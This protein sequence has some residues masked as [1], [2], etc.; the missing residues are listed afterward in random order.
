VQKTL[1][2][3]KF[4]YNRLHVIG[5][6]LVAAR[7][8]HLH[9][10]NLTDGSHVSAWKHP[11]V[12]SVS[13]DLN[14]TA[15]AEVKGNE[16]SIEAISAEQ[17]LSSDPAEPPA[18]RQKTANTP[19][20]DEEPPNGA[21]GGTRKKEKRGRGTVK[22]ENA[23]SRQTFMERPLVTLLASSADGTYLIAVS[24]H[25]KTVWVFQHDGQGNLKQISRRYV[26]GDFCRALCSRRFCF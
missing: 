19:G 15:E 14:M 13:T 7:L 5:D 10:F 9:T 1:T 24:G 3:M 12:K 6:V 18:K 17:P 23:R 11:D 4:P 8:G 25:D 16:P 2:N 21:E 22:S 20:Q 26:Y